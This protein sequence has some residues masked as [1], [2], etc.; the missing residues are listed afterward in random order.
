MRHVQAAGR[1]SFRTSAY[2]RAQGTDGDSTSMSRR[3]GATAVE[4]QRAMANQ[5]PSTPSSSSTGTSSSGRAALVRI[6]TASSGASEAMLIADLACPR[7][8]S[9][10]EALKMPLS[11]V[12][13]DL[14]ARDSPKRTPTQHPVSSTVVD[15]DPDNDCIRVELPS[16][17]Y[18]HYMNQIFSIKLSVLVIP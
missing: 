18:S 14:I 6:N 2:G 3:P 1:K 11:V 5:N 15:V 4:I 13:G 9:Y 12:Q 10:H 16:A 8:Q 7:R 17:R